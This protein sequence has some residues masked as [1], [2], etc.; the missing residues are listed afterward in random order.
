LFYVKASY[1]YVEAAMLK[2]AIP[3]FLIIIL[4]AC[5]PGMPADDSP[6]QKPVID[7]YK[8]NTLEINSGESAEITWSVTG[9]TSV[10]MDPNVGIMPSSGSIEVTPVETT[11]YTIHAVNDSGTVE[12][13]LTI[14]VN[15]ANPYISVD[16]EDPRLPTV[17]VLLAPVDGAVF[18]N[19]PRT[20]KLKWQASKGEIPITYILKI[21]YDTRE[22]PGSFEGSYSPVTLTN[23]EYSLDFVGKGRGRWCVMSKNDFGASEYSGWRYFQFTK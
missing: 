1:I 11:V 16:A 3:L 17:P 5:T 6:L 7:V 13:S 2:L 23:I 14:K 22:T 8:V 19:Y 20:V 10:D 9:A 12:D 18:S 15:E 4:V 21:Q